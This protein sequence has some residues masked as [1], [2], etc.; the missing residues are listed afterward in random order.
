MAEIASPNPLPLLLEQ[1]KQIDKNF[2]AVKYKEKLWKC[3]KCDKY[4]TKAQ[5]Y[6][7]ILLSFEEKMMQK[8]ECL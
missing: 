4:G 8:S 5:N 1:L 6:T 3:P 2:P 7:K